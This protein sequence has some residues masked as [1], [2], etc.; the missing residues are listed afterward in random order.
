VFVVKYHKHIH[1]SNLL[2]KYRA[3]QLPEIVLCSSL[4]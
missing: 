2:L 4:I 1:P 3:T